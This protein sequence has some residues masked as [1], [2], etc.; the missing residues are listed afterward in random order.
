MRSGAWAAADAQRNAQRPSSHWR[1]RRHEEAL[2]RFY[3]DCF[4]DLLYPFNS[5]ILSSYFYT[6]STDSA[7]ISSIFSSLSFVLLVGVTV[8]K[9][10]TFLSVLD[11]SSNFLS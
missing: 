6:F 4:V 11:F 2:V 1:W 9:E 7:E 10:K 5:I 8:P 3:V